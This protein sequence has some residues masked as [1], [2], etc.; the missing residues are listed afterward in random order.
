MLTPRQ[1]ECLAAIRAHIAECGRSPTVG[2]L[3]ARLGLV[4]HSAAH[5]LLVALRARGAIRWRAGVPR[6]ITLAEQDMPLAAFYRAE[7]F[8][9]ADGERDTRFVLVAVRE[10]P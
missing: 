1:A 3:G 7:A 9:R 5:R 4:S 10:G 6:S 2:E 8:I